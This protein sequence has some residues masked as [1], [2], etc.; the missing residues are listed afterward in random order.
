MAA[1][2][3][4]AGYWVRGRGGDFVVYD[5]ARYLRPMLEENEANG[6]NIKI[7]GMGEPA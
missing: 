7:V 2:P 4:T 6:E 5:L 3:F 1:T